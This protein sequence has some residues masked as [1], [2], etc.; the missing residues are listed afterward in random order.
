MPD[1]EVMGSIAEEFPDS[2]FQFCTKG[3]FDCV[4][5]LDASVTASALACDMNRVVHKCDQFEKDHPELKGT[6]KLVDCSSRSVCDNAPNIIDYGRSCHEGMKGAWT[7]L[8]KAAAQFVTGEGA[9]P[10]V[11]SLSKLQFFK[12]CTSGECKRKMLGPFASYFS[13][14]E[15]EG[16]G[17]QKGISSD[18]IV[19][20]NYIEGYSAAVLYRKLLQKLKK[21]I[22]TKKMDQQF[23]EPW[24][25][26]VAKMP[27]SLNQ[28]IDNIL[29]KAGFGN[30][31][32]LNPEVVAK[33][34]CYAFFSIFDPTLALGL[35]PKLVRA[36]GLIVRETVAL[37]SK[38][39]KGA[40]A[41]DLIS[42]QVSIVWYPKPKYINATH[43][44]LKVGDRVYDL[45][46]NVKNNA[47]AKAVERAANGNG[48]GYIEFKLKVTQ[49]ELDNL[50]KTLVEQEG[51]PAGPTCIGGVCNALQNST[52]IVIP[53]PFKY[54]PSMAAVY[55]TAAKKLGYTRISDIKYVGKGSAA[56]AV[57]SVQVGVETWMTY[58]AGKYAGYVIVEG[59]DFAGNTIRNIVPIETDET[60]KS[61][62]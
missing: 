22:E 11:E 19:N 53:P 58:T 47:S 12:E 62:K 45:T 30:T 42:D 26:E 51:K 41:K 16:V 46:G 24:S 48:R 7:D 43:A 37:S 18:D 57:S 20:K 54:V 36:S 38:T 50:K 15:I 21:D 52:D 29:L 32:C 61:G 4:G 59:V 39:I 6:G 49:K 34:R 33:M 17:P 14:E 44:E 5:R 56:K 10:S 13:K 9:A 28:Q 40:M 8:A 25:G 2:P 31:G 55:M 60:D 35:L 27:K 3:E 23:I 1:E